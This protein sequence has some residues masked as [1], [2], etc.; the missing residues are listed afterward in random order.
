MAMAVEIYPVIHVK[1]PSQAADQAEIAFELD[2][3]GVYLIDHEAS[4]NTE[5]VIEAFNRV[6]STDDMRFVGI[7][8][9]QISSGVRALEHIR[10][11]VETGIMARLPNGLWVDDADPGKDDLVTLRNR[12]P[13]LMSVRY[14]GGVAFKY[15]DHFTEDPEESAQEAIRLSRYVDVVTTSGAGTGIP[16]TVDKIIA[17]KQSIGDQR[18][19]IASGVSLANL[20]EFLPNFDELLV[21]SSV[22]TGRYSGE[23]DRLRLRDLIADAHE[24]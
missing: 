7:N 23:F 24:L 21:S 12:Y 3:D 19:A 13:E 18:L 20:E 1:D 8:L 4:D 17:M 15:T 5:R 16:P 9:L 6:A 2:A 10:S 14:L 11:R 22:E